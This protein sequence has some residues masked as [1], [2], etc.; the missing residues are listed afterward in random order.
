VARRRSYSR[1][2]QSAGLLR[3]PK[4]PYWR[5]HSLDGGIRAKR[6]ATFVVGEFVGRLFQNIGYLWVIPTAVRESKA[7]P[8]YLK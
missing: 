5:R 3:S 6:T 2:R 7:V 4:G 8:N 1:L